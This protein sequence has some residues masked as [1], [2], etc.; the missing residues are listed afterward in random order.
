MDLKYLNDFIYIFIFSK[1]FFCR[2]HLHADD[3]HVLF[4]FFESRIFREIYYSKYCGHDVMF[5]GIFTNIFILWMDYIRD[6]CKGRLVKHQYKTKCY[7]VINLQ[8]SKVFKVLFS[9]S[10]LSTLASMSS[11]INISFERHNFFWC[12]S[13]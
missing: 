8:R 11:K 10:R 1:F 13:V 7:I 4:S 6:L 5:F 12:A 3:L 2:R 9:N